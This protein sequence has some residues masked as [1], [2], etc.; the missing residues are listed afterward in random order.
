MSDSFFVDSNILIY[1]V[2]E[3]SIKC[4]IARQLLI[5]KANHI[6]ISSQVINEFVAVLIKKNL[7]FLEDIFAYADG[8]MEIFDFVLITKKNIKIAMNIKKRYKF[9]YWDSLIVASALENDCSILYTEDMQDGQII[10]GRL[11]VVNPFG[12]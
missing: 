9:S 7:L 12:G 11:K 3:N 5:D 8:F 6:M 4:D 10:E 2:C 1:A